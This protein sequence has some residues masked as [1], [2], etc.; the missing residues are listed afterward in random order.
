MVYG[1]LTQ[2]DASGTYLG[3]FQVYQAS[4]LLSSGLYDIENAVY[5]NADSGEVIV[6]GDDDVF[7]PGSCGELCFTCAET[8]S[9]P[10]D[11]IGQSTQGRVKYD[12]NPSS[13]SQDTLNGS[14]ITVKLP[15]GGACAASIEGTYPITG[16]LTIVPASN[17]DPSVQNFVDAFNA[18]GPNFTA[19]AIGMDDAGTNS[20][21]C[22]TVPTGL[23]NILIQISTPGGSAWTQTWDDTAGVWSVEDDNGNNFVGGSEA[24]C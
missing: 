20:I 3:Q 14:E 18:I 2:Y 5:Q 7:K 9:D 6:K 1:C 8:D 24:E 13:L 21:M 19:E 11:G 12:V 4:P 22:V 16:T 15:D 17:G 10:C 23:G